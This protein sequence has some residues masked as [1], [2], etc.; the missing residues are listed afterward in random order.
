MLDWDELKEEAV[1]GEID[2]FFR[3]A[4]IAD[5]PSFAD[6]PEGIVVRLLEDYR[7]HQ[8]EVLGTQVA[9][10][11]LRRSDASCDQTFHR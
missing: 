11:G 1:E 3:K 6:M 8:H 10:P 2:D 9:R 5:M 4:D 7:A